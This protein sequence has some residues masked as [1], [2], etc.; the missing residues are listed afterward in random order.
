M[1]RV[2]AMCRGGVGIAEGMGKERVGWGG[3]VE[4]KTLVEG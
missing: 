2:G 3:G 4:D 1:G